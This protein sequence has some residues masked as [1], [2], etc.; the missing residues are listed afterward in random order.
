M[1]CI[2][3]P[4]SYSKLVWCGVK[5]LFDIFPSCVIIL[6]ISAYKEND[7]GTDEVH[8]WFRNGDSG[9]YLRTYLQ[10]L[11]LVP[12]G[13]RVRNEVM[14]GWNNFYGLKSNSNTHR[15]AAQHESRSQPLSCHLPQ[16]QLCG[17][18]PQSC[19]NAA[20]RIAF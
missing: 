17:E 16:N 12:I 19:S 14:R 4:L 5:D 20:W 10:Y 9:V 3:R 18:P 11:I 7:S 1:L 6:F 8:R 13:K 2:S 15:T